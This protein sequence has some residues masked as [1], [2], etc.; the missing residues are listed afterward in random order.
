MHK[1]FHSVFQKKE[2]GTGQFKYWLNVDLTFLTSINFKKYLQRL[3]QCK[4]I[5]FQIHKIH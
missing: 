1:A 3:K 4:N 2:L 5:Y